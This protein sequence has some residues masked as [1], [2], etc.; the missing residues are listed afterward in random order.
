MAQISGFAAMALDSLNPSQLAFIHSLPKAE[1]HAHLNG[2]IPISELQ[3]MANEY[4]QTSDNL[5]SDLVREGIAKLK[6][7]VA[8]D[9]IYDFF[10]L[11]PAIYALTSN[12]ANLRRATRA[13]LE[14]FLDG[15]RPQC[16]YLELRSTPRETAEMSK[17]DYVQAVLDEVERYPASR[18]S[19]IV[20]LDRRMTTRAAQECVEIAHQLKAEGRR[21]VGVDL[22][23]DPQAGD[24]G[25]F[26]QQFHDAKEA[27]LGIT[28][29]IAET[30]ANPAEEILQ[31]LSYAPDRLGHATFLDDEGK[32][33][34]RGNKACIEICLSSNL[35]CKTVAKLD[36]HHIRYYLQHDHPIAI[37][38][39]DTLPF[40]TS[41][42]GEYAL[43][44]ASPPLGLGLSEPEQRDS[45]FAELLDEG[46]IPFVARLLLHSV[47]IKAK[48]R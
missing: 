29:H 13:V 8:L 10:N 37:C 39:D 17:L 41:L 24:M 21:V 47:P 18:A 15:D 11:F 22:C 23:G 4:S 30:P 27:G 33:I 46:D 48:I 44:L 7:G 38:T 20:S 3:Q 43:L 14:Q 36:D 45:E 32:A 35:L 5:A 34:V 6:R 9:E 2:S 26:E 25:T 1:L 19:L 42:P 28:L 16:T 12:P 31:L 40:R